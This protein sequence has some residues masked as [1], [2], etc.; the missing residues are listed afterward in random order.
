MKPKWIIAVLGLMLIFSAI[1]YQF[2]NTSKRDVMMEKVAYKIG[3]DELIDLFEKNET[4]ANTNF[5]NKIVEV[6]GKI[7]EANKNQDDGLIIILKERDEI[8]GI[9]CAFTNFN[10]KL[11]QFI[12]GDSICIRGIVQGYLDDVI[13]N[14]CQIIKN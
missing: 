1:V 7:G 2:I 12:V 14:N 8:Y 6:K 3:A 11:D 9:N 4:L 5:V 10:F 13:I